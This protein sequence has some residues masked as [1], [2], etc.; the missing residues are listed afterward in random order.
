MLAGLLAF[1]PAQAPEAHGEPAPADRTNSSWSE[2]SV[3]FHDAWRGLASEIDGDGQTLYLAY[4]VVAYH[5]ALPTSCPYPS[6]LWVQRGT[7]FAEVRRLWSYRDN[8]ECVDGHDSAR[9]VIEPHWIFAGPLT[10]DVRTGLREFD[11]S[12]PVSRLRIRT[13]PSR[14]SAMASAPR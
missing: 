9:V 7:V 2:R 6:P 14:F 8:L 11:C 12:D 5:M 13:C 1:L 4:G 10:A 3:A